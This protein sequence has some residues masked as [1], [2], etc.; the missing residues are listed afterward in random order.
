[1]T[2][3]NNPSFQAK[4]KIND[5]H[6]LLLKYQKQE[7]HDMASKIGTD[8]DTIE[9]DFGNYI[10]G[11]EHTW[12]EQGSGWFRAKDN[13]F[14]LGDVEAKIGNKDK[15][16]E[17][18]GYGCRSNMG[19]MIFEQITDYFNKLIDNPVEVDTT[20]FWKKNDKAQERYDRKHHLGR[21]SKD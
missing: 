14:V 13:D 7:L 10:E 18:V 2:T 12:S 5:K 9:I 17:V 11:E 16:T 3:N 8:E 21:F 6:N 4:L 19:D 20:D 1:M 15:S